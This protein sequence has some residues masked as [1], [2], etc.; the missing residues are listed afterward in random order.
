MNISTLCTLLQQAAS[1]INVTGVTVTLATGDQATASSLVQQLMYLR[2]D[3][4]LET[5]S[6]DVSGDQLIIGCTAAVPAPPE[7]PAT[8]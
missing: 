2:G 7:E 6:F 4:Q 8:E 3:G 5:F 1:D